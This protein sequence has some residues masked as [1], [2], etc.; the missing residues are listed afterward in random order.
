MA[1]TPTGYQ[2]SFLRLHIPL[3]QLSAAQQ[4]DAAPIIGGTQVVVPYTNFSLVMSKTRRLA[5]YTGVNINGKSLVPITRKSATETWRYDKRIER[6][7]QLG[8]VFYKDNPYDQGHLVRRLDPVWGR[9]ALDGL[10]E[11]FFYTNCAPQHWDLNRNTW[12]DLED[13]VLKN[14]DKNDLRV[15]VFT[16]PVFG[17]NDPLEKDVRIPVEFWKVVAMVRADGTPSATA[18]LLSQRDL[19]RT[20]DFAFGA[21]RT[22]QVLIAEIERLTS[23]SFGN[24]RAHDPLSRQRDLFPAR[25]LRNLS[26]IVL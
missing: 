26:E 17:A 18:Y 8:G 24:L 3:P 12:S 21:F 2:A 6:K 7:F 10:R 23:L 1:K 16:G 25:Q 19:I 11:T 22:Y 14:T 9:N 15:S 4:I 20:R 13:Y 5:I